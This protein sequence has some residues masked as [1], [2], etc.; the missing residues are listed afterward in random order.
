M[1]QY[2]PTRVEIGAQDLS[3]GVFVAGDL[4]SCADESRTSRAIHS[5]DVRIPGTARE[6][7]LRSGHRKGCE[8]MSYAVRPQN[9]RKP[10]VQR[11]R[12]RSGVKVHE[13]PHEQAPELGKAR[14][15]VRIEHAGADARRIVVCTGPSA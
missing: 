7:K 10:R 4:T 3:G 2:F 11:Q 15:A 8:H 9:C 6:G 1:Q 12:L 5:I 14:F 13:W